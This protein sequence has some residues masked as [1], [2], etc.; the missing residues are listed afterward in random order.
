MPTHICIASTS[1]IV[2]VSTITINRL[3]FSVNDCVLWYYCG[4]TLELVR[5]ADCEP[6][7]K[8]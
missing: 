2:Y 7:T 1:P 3:R 8:L 5:Q 4:D 6:L